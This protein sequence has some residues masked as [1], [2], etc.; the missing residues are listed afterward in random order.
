[1]TAL[2]EWQRMLPPVG[3]EFR[4][5]RGELNIFNVGAGD[6]QIQITGVEDEAELAKIRQRIEGMLKQ[7]Y[8]LL[9]ADKRGRLRRIKKFDPKKLTYTISLDEGPDAEVP[10]SKGKATAVPRSAGG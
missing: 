10:V 7:G 2:A 8:V 9:A 4:H 1:M 6:L 5:D 3:S